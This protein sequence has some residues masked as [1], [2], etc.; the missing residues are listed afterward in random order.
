LPSNGAY[1]INFTCFGQVVP[2]TWGATFELVNIPT[3]PTLPITVDG[4]SVAIAT[5]YT[6]QSGHLTFSGTANQQLYMYVTTPTGS[7][8]GGAGISMVDVTT[9]HS[10]LSGNGGAPGS[11]WT[12]CTAAI[13]LPDNGNYTINFTPFGQIVPQTWGATFQLTSSA[14]P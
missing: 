14:C 9:N 3:D 2:Q 10:I 4:S 11:G 1:S 13:T 6:G 7:D 8:Q 12:W 5:T